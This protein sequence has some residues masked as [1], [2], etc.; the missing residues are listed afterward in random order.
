MWG[1]HAAIRGDRPMRRAPTKSS[2][3][4]Q[5][6]RQIARAIA[7]GA[8]P[9]FSAEVELY[10][11]TSPREIFTCF[12]EAA[13]HM[14]PAGSD[15]SLAIA[16]LFLLQRLLEHL[17]YRTDNGYSDAATLI[18]EFQAEVVAQVEAERVDARMLA[19]VAGALHQSKIPASPALAAAVSRHPFG[20]DEDTPLPIDVRAALAGMLETCG[21]DPFM[22]VDTLM[23]AAH[24]MP[25]DARSTLA[26]ALALSGLAEARAA[27]VLLLLDREP[28]VRGT[29]AG[30]LAQAAAALTP[31]DLRRMIAVRNWRPENERAAIDAIVRK[32]RAAGIDCAPWEAG[33]VET[34]L[35]S[36]IDGSGAQGFF[37]MSATGRKMRVS[38]ILTKRGIADASTG[39]PESLR[40]IETSLKE[41]DAPM[42]EVSRAYLDGMVADQLAFG[43]ATGEVPPPGLL[44][45]AET[46]GGVDWQ[47]ARLS[48]TEAIAGLIAEAPKSLRKP[49][50]VAT[51][52]RRSDELVDLQ[53]VAQSW[54]EDDPQIAQAVER[55]G[56]RERRKLADHLLHAYIARHRERWTDIVGRTALWMRATSSPDQLCWPELA[57]VAKALADGH[58]M[59][60]IGLMRDVALRTIAALSDTRRLR[61]A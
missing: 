61:R 22:L 1:Y 12:G 11:E 20:A 45:V 43:L 17:R 15:G 4:H 56:R 44:Q 7:K 29:V 55:T 3:T 31:T 40:Q 59:T 13:R 48:I 30:A 54:F 18:A 39:E 35:A 38:T 26:A 19:F 16:Y 60:S 41:T 57:I 32:A 10:C 50:A 23:E 36:C 5:H 37:L 21:G 28:G 34:I 52:L 46:I 47:P 25:A 51:T 49:A 8:P 42:L 27:A 2:P 24:A 14:P 33:G 6:A 9:P 53:V 58:D